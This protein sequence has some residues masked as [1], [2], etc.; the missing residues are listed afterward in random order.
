[1]K[2]FEPISLTSAFALVFS[3]TA[4]GGVGT[5]GPGL[6]STPPP[7]PLPGDTS[8]ELVQAPPNGEFAVLGVGDPLRIRY[9]S[10]AGRYE[11]QA[12]GEDWT[13]LVDSTGNNGNPN[14][15]FMFA[16]R[17]DWD[18][19][20]SFFVQ[21][22]HRSPAES[23]RYR[24]S[25][26]AGWTLRTAGP[27]EDRV[28]QGVVA[29]GVATPP[30]GVPVVGTGRY[31]GQI[32]GTSDVP[33]TSGWGNFENAPIGGTVALDF[34]FAGGTLSGVMA[35]RLACDC[36]PIT[37]PVL[38]F[39]DTV[40]GVGNNAFSGRFDTQAAG[41]NYFSGLF[42]GP[43]AEELIGHWAFPFLYQGEMRSVEGAWIAK[44]RQ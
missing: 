30:G 39:T 28:Q 10:A 29:L 11:V 32:A 33:A 8:V 21:A 26:L 24:Y 43:Q 40:F 25:N 4:C 3:L 35:P 34:D 6:G 23:S 27:M 41:S 15:G 20:S 31:E 42:T 37:F 13:A 12:E 7:P 44:A 1:M 5:N 18:G 17:A 9:D 14:I 19:G 16:S 2:R 38:S 22:H 36:D